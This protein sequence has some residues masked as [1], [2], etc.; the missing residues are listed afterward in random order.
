MLAQLY[1]AKMTSVLPVFLIIIT[2][3]YNQWCEYGRGYLFG[4]GGAIQ[5]IENG[6]FE[7]PVRKQ[8]L[9]IMKHKLTNCS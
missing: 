8:S 3:N 1:G 7:K 6:V 5:P 9:A 2:I 4:M